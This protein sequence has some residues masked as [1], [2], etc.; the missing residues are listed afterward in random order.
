MT[1][2]TSV[3]NQSSAQPISPA[4]ITLPPTTQIDLTW[5]MSATG[6]AAVLEA[7]P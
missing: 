1:E 2:G 3:R 4:D 5:L 7:L 6:K